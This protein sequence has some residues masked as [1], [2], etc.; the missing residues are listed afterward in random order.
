[1]LRSKKLRLILL[2]T[3]FS[4]PLQSFAG[5]HGLGVGRDMKTWANR[6]MKDLGTRF[7]KYQGEFFL[8]LSSQEVN[9][10]SENGDDIQWLIDNELP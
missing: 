9:Q 8:A 7:A 4:V 2:V 5:I 10:A 3:V 1:M 6:K